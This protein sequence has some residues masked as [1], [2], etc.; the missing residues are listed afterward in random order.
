MKDDEPDR[1][2]GYLLA[3]FVGAILA[4]VL[5]FACAGWGANY[6]S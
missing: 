3:L 2:R 5:A 4:T 6:F 1:N